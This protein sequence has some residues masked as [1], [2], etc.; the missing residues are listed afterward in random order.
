MGYPVYYTGELQVSPPLTEED[1]SVLLAVANLEKTE[2]ARAVF[3]VIKASSEPDLPY[4]S[5]LLE[6]SEDRTLI[7]PEDDESRHGLRMWLVLLIEYFLEPRGY[8]LNGEIWW[9]AED[10]REDRGCIYVKDN[11]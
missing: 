1:A 9:T 11:D 5:G 3:A 6:V 8:V 10:D 4:H 2:E 7:V